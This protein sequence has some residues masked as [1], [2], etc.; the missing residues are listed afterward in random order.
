MLRKGLRLSADAHSRNSTH[1]MRGCVHAQPFVRPEDEA[2]HAGPAEFAAAGFLESALPR[3]RD[4]AAGAQ[5]TWQ[6]KLRQ[7]DLAMAYAAGA[8]VPSE[9]TMLKEL[10]RW[11]LQNTPEGARPAAP[12]KATETVRAKANTAR[13]A[14]GLPEGTWGKSPVLTPA[15]EVMVERGLPFVLPAVDGVDLMRAE[16][17]GAAV[18]QSVPRWAA[19]TVKGLASVR[20]SASCSTASA[21]CDIRDVQREGVLLCQK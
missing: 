9:N 13:R 1:L 12:V 2:G 4:G 7:G 11:F 8:V 17:K 16:V 3:G 18:L 14:R 10:F 21:H 20:S 15:D 19:S 6:E 5:V